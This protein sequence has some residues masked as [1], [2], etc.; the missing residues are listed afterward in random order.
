MR[1]INLICLMGLM[2]LMSLVFPSPAKAGETA[3]Q[4][5][6]S[7]YFNPQT[8]VTSK[9]LV[10]KAEEVR[11]FTDASGL[12]GCQIKSTTWQTAA[13]G[14]SALTLNTWSHISC[15]YDKVNLRI[16]V[17]G[18]QVGSQSLTVAVDDTANNFLVGEDDSADALYTNFIGT[19]DQFQV[20]N[21]ART[22]KQIVQDMNAGHPA[23][24]SPVGSAVGYWDFD[25][26]YGT[27]ANDSTSN[28]NNLTLSS[29]SWTDSGKFGKAWNGTGAIWLSKADD[30]DF[31]V[32][33]TDDY[34]I[35]LWFKSDSANNPGAA[36]YLFNKANATT[37]GYAIYTNTSGYLCFGID[38]DTTWG[39]DI[40][41]CTSTDVYDNTWHHVA[42]VRDVTQ[43]KTYIYI[44]GVLK[45]SDTDTTTATLANSLSIYAGDR[46]GVDNGDEFNGDLDE[47][48]VYRYALTADEVKVDYN[49]GSSQ[50]LGSL[51]DNSSYQPQAAN[52]E[53]CIPGDTTSCTAPVARWDFENNVLDTSGN[54]YNGTWYGTGFPRYKSGKVGKAGNFNGTDDYA[55]KTSAI[56][57]T[58]GGTL[59]YWMNPNFDTTSSTTRGLFYSSTDT[60]A[61]A[62]QHFFYQ[63]KLR[64]SRGGYAGLEYTTP[65][66]WQNTWKHITYTYDSS[67]NTI[68]YVNG[69]QVAS[70]NYGGT[71]FSNASFEIGRTGVSGA[72][73]YFN[74]Q[75]DQVRIFNYARSA[76]QI[77]W[78]YNRGAPVGY[79]KMDECQGTTA[80]DSS[81]N[82][83][84]GTITI[85]ATGGED[86]VGTCSTSSTAWGSGATGKR[87]Y[88][89]SLDG[90]DDKVAVADTANLR[91]NNSTDDFSLF[92]WVK[93]TTT[94]AEYILSKEDADNDGYRLLFTGSNT[95]Q[96]S[97]DAT[98][99][100][101]T[102]TIAD[103]NWH[104]IGCTI[105]RDGN[106]QIYI[107]GKADGSTAAMGTDA[108][109]TTS[110][111]TLGTRSYTSTSYFNG[112]IDDVRIYNYALTVTQV[113][114][115]YN[116]GAVN[117]APS[118]GAP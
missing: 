51:S 57:V 44:D 63:G 25:E 75:I 40:A 110:N 93:R 115:L 32:T 28:A 39:P 85:G 16:Y 48:K 46:D 1:Y 81:G 36:E 69:V 50:V 61:S 79:W 13:S 37:A 55:E 38:D 102:S 56:L 103:T 84:T 3:N 15:T 5:T 2:T 21:Y 74:G 43:D 99:V 67:G 92:A 96:C 47:I 107:D 108:M 62:L 27:T 54:A 42:A 35:S 100:T 71:T 33:D 64:F 24:G 104:L 31:D 59:S 29:T 98:D 101:S 41:S 6:I 91:F 58:T 14:T 65:T 8:S 112:Q 34:S 73:K 22:Q 109:A 26:G 83:N 10:G 80:N 60:T 68:L 118:S 49:R 12:P 19:V 11:L 88:S 4:F 30:S 111:I 82:G 17:N 94:G 52:Q 76:A 45:D 106:G 53:Y 95:V 18:V 9:A 77:A 105:D 7:L 87:N 23:V 78:D 116:G 90:T 114:D 117:F 113:K 97:E 72:W 89:L 66:N 86:T 20:Y 70:G